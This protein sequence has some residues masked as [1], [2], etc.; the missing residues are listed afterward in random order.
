MA[1][2]KRGKTW[3]TDFTVNGQRFRQSLDTTDWR[4]AQSKQKELIAQASEGKITPKAQTFYRL[5]FTTATE[6]HL[7]DRTPHL[8]P[9]SI[10]TEK[11][12]LK[13]LQAYFSKTPLLLITAEALRSYISE[14]RKK[15]VANKTINLEIGVVRGVLKRAKRWHLI[16]DEIR[17][18]PARHQ[19]GRVLEK[20]QKQDLA[21]LATTNPD[22]ENA[23][24]AMILALN[25]TMRSCEVKALQWQD[26]DFI[27]RTITIRHSKT[28]AGRRL[29]PLNSAAWAA[30]MELY[31]RAEQLEAREPDHFVFPA[32][33]NG[34]I[35]P[36]KPQRSWRSAWRSLTR[37][38]ECPAC[39]KLQRPAKACSNDACKADISKIKSAFFGLRFHDLRHHAITELAESLASD[40]TIMAIAGHVSRE[41]LQ[42]YSH[43]RL[44]AKRR[45]VEA[46]SGDSHEEGSYVTKYVTNR[47]EKPKEGKTESPNQTKDWSGREDLNLRPPGP[48]ILG[49]GQVYSY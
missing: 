38:V 46:L 13:P 32:C 49:I 10:E 41:M 8:A 11:E 43:V 33:E 21:R 24:L 23:R 12:R 17:P 7:D 27:E 29:I 47:Q 45:A 1:L 37:T 44:E 25:T 19:V 39:R 31:H 9:K 5:G 48:E 40:Q 42:H 36:T 28:D 2:Y 20:E 35:S 14:R 26:V 30:I 3:H 34:K 22:W 4:E 6:R 18:L 16:A 15:G